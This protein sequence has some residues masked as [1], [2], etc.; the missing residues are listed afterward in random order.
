MNIK[1]IIVD[2][3]DNFYLLDINGNCYKIN[4]FTYNHLLSLCSLGDFAR[5]APKEISIT[6]EFVSKQIYELV[7]SKLNSANENLMKGVSY[8]YIKGKFAG[9][10]K[11]H[12]YKTLKP[13][14]VIFALPVLI[15]ATIASLFCSVFY[16]ST[17]HLGIYQSDS[18]FSIA[19]LLILYIGFIIIGSLHEL[20]HSIASIHYG[21]NPKEI[22]IGFY[23]FRLVLYVDV[24]SIWK[25]SS[26]RRIVVNFGGIYIQ[27]LINLALVAGCLIFDN[28]TIKLIFVSNC[29]NIF[30]NLIPFLKSDGYWILSDLLKITNWEQ[31]STQYVSCKLKKI[32]S[33]VECDIQS[34][35]PQVFS[36]ETK[37]YGILNF[38]YWLILVLV[39]TPIIFKFLFT[40]LMT[41]PFTFYNIFWGVVFF[42]YTYFSLQ[43]IKQ[44]ALTYIKH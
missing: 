16:L 30:F 13:I 27:L 6:S 33:R 26:F 21:V 24:T 44:R 17:D 19:N 35:R 7:A 34:G 22:G 37:V 41:P 8:D 42:V 20:G 36:T 12:H 43:S 4:E 9:K 40:R 31:K 5:T 38:L 25:L 18:H 1:L 23:Y 39:F 11:P 32:V 15:T 29:F 2:K 28:E 3:G 10:F 14:G